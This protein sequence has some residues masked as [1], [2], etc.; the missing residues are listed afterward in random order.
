VVENHALEFG[1]TA[2]KLVREPDVTYRISLPTAV[3]NG[4]VA[5]VDGKLC[6]KIAAKRC[7]R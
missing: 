6:R 7:R 2:S 1:F 4:L 3:L 5:E